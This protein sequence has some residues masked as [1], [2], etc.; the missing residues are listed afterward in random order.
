MAYADVGSAQN[1][2]ANAIPDIDNRHNIRLP[3]KSTRPDIAL[4]STSQSQ[5]GRISNITL[6]ELKYCR[7]SDITPQLDRATCQHQAL[8]AHL[9]QLHQC[10]TQTLPI[11]LGVSG[12]IYSMHTA[13]ALQ[14]LGVRGSLLKTTLRRLHTQA[15]QSLGSIVSTRRRS[16]RKYQS[17]TGQRRRQHGGK[18]PGQDTH[19]ARHRDNG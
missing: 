8:A 11:L 18:G 4:A 9:S 3:P 2:Q 16:E 5:P 10:S 15:I 12:A 7:D 17:A 6:V 14:Q 13:G 1:L 19:T